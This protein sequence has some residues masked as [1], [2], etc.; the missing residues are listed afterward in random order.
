MSETLAWVVIVTGILGEL[1]TLAYRL[2]RGY[3]HR[4]DWPIVVLGLIFETA[5]FWLALRT[6]W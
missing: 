6:V 3:L 5:A 4:R 2:H 1:V